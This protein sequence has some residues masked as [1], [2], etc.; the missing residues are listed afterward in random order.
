[1]VADGDTDEIDR[2]VGPTFAPV[3][4]RLAYLAK[5]ALGG[6]TAETGSVV[7]V[8]MQTGLERLIPAAPIPPG[9]R[10]SDYNM[11]GG[12]GFW[13]PH[14]PRWS[15]EG[16]ELLFIGSDGVWGTSVLLEASA[17]GDE[18]PDAVSETWVAEWYGS[19]PF[20]WQVD[21]P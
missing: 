13:Q 17:T 9:T 15:P 16:T 10:L 8:D 2:G 21:L 3:G 7:V 18:I 1:M 4:D 14:E 6:Q 20:S 11:E 5:P 12:S 19:N